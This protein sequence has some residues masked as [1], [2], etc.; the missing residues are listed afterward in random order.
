ML[1]P[2]PEAV[3]DNCYALDDRELV[4]PFC[5][6]APLLQ[7]TV[8]ALDDV[9]SAI[10]LRIELRSTPTLRFAALPMVLLIGLIDDGKPSMAGGRDGARG[11]CLRDRND[12]SC[13]LA[14]YTV[15]ASGLVSPRLARYGL[16]SAR[17]DL[18]VQ[19]FCLRFGLGEFPNAAGQ[20]CAGLLQ[21]ALADD[22]RYPLVHPPLV[23]L[24][25]E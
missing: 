23:S 20:H 5:E 4:V 21:S 12:V 10:F 18:S 22:R 11:A 2:S 16:P 19:R 25:R 7:S 14:G 8:A 6:P 13:W 17:I 24:G 15:A 1:Q 9:A 3:E